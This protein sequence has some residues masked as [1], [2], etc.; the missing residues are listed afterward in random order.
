MEIYFVHATGHLTG[1]GHLQKMSDTWLARTTTYKTN[2][3]NCLISLPKK[4]KVYKG[5]VR[6]S[7]Y[8]FRYGPESVFDGKWV[9]MMTALVEDTYA[10]AGNEK[11]AGSHC[12]SCRN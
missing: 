11:V 6:G 1:R 5:S 2:T 9:T 10:N 7:P 12:G 8:D 3:M 4:T